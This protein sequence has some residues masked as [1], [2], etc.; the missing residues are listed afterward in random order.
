MTKSCCAG[1]GTGRN[2]AN[3]SDYFQPFGA[4][5]ARAGLE[6]KITSYALRHSSI[7]R[8]L[9]AGIPVSI[10]SRLH[11]TSAREIE[12]HCGKYILDVSEQ[13]ARRSLLTAPPVAAN[14]V[15]LR[16]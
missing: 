4:V 6:P 14:V 13:L 16:K 2:T 12:S 5:V 11:D 8:A 1:D 10:V 3:K 7:C 9:L 15:A